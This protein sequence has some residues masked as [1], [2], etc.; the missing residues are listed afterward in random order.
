MREAHL[1][2]PR[3]YQPRTGGLCPALADTGGADWS[4]RSESESV[5]GNWVPVCKLGVVAAGEVVAGKR[6]TD[7]LGLA[8][9]QPRAR[10]HTP[11][12]SSDC[13]D[14]PVVLALQ[15]LRWRAS[16]ANSQDL[17]A[18]GPAGVQSLPTT[19]GVAA[20]RPGSCCHTQPVLP[21]RLGGAA[22]WEAVRFGWRPCEHDS[23]AAKP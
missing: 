18:T 22:L 16:H 8:S 5:P 4:H 21:Q 1:V 14:T 2:R 7:G 15:C 6:T 10:N 20:I 3:S 17:G 12:G 13:T 9:S 23:Q 11:W 19:L